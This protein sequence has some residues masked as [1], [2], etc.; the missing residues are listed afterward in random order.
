MKN[1]QVNFTID[2]AA[3]VNLKG[4]NFSGLTR[5]AEISVNDSD[6]WG[7]GLTPLFS[8]LVQSMFKGIAKGQ[9]I[10]WAMSVSNESG[11]VLV[12]GSEIMKG[13]SVS[14]AKAIFKAIR[15]Q[16]APEVEGLDMQNLPK[17]SAIKQAYKDAA[18]KRL[19]FAE[20]CNN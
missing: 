19:T 7:K 1:T 11:S 8:Q 14:T 20:L 4:A 18:N 13:D 17:I 3:F 5:H 6:T 10:E 15:V 9:P 12:E 16:F 2:A